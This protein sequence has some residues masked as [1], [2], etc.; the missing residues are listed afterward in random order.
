MS[1]NIEQTVI[2]GLRRLTSE[3][4]QEVAD[5]V[6]QL[7]EKNAPHKTIWEKID[8]RVKQVPPEVWEG[9][10]TDGAEQYDHYLYGAP[11]K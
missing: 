7:V 9:L 5:F 10:P 11:K 4:K 6:Q 1:T 2:E 8:E 3:Q